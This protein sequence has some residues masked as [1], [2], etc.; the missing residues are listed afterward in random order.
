VQADSS[1]TVVWP[2]GVVAQAIGNV[3]RNALQASP[4]DKLT[5]LEAAPVS[6]DR[7]RIVTIDQGRG[8]SPDELARAGEPFFTTKPP[9]AGTGLG[10]FVTRSAV[11]QLGGTLELNSDRERG[12]IATILLP[13][14]VT[15]PNE[16]RATDE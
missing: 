6:D 13:R 12:T 8:M 7:V 4:Q 10:L 9:G 15:A 5:R 1:A 11:E 16:R 3:L 14:D 2:V